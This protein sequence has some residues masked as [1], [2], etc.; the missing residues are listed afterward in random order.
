MFGDASQVAADNC[1]S[2]I[3]IDD[4]IDIMLSFIM[5]INQQKNAFYHKFCINE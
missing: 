2:L 4:A 5:V 3:V 1:P